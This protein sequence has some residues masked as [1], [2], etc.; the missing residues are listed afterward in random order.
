M[1]QIPKRLRCQASSE[2]RGWMLLELFVSIFLLATLLVLINQSLVMLHHQARLANR[3]F[4]AQQVLENLMEES[5]L[6]PWQSLSTAT[7]Q[8]LDLPPFALEKLPGCQL[9]AE[10]RDSQEPIPAKQITFRLNWPARN[11]PRQKP[12]ALTTWTY[13]EPQP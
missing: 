13:Q 4:I 11:N 1:N 3:R 7:V 10:V 2:R 6:I 12:V 8:E 5:L 9:E